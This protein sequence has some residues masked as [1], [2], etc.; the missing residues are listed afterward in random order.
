MIQAPDFLAEF[1]MNGWRKLEIIVVGAGGTGSALL[2]KLFQLDM[3]LRNLG[4]PG[5][6]V[7]V[8]DDDIVTAS[9]IGRQ[10]FWQADLN[11]PKASV[12]VDRYNRFGGL[13]W[14]AVTEKYIPK[15]SYFYTSEGVV[16][17]GCVD[18]VDGRKTIHTMMQQ[19]RQTVWIDCGNDSRSANVL[20]GMKANVAG[21]QVYL[22]SVYDLFKE[23]FDSN[24]IKPEPSCSTAEAIARQAFGIND[25]TAAQAVQILWQL[26]RH[27]EISYQGVTIDLATGTT[28]PI[29]ADPAIW[30]MFGYVDERSKKAA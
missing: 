20:M 4:S 23:Q 1:S 19:K 14:K 12:L 21:E 16:I 29:E 11:Q 18:N 7:T 24:T 30:A 15:E 13:N 27:G 25:I 26:L 2:N 17:F 28:N 6:S 3:T 5:F 8:Y 22:P 10:A 9:N